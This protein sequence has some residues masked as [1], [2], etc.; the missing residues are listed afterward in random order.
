MQYTILCLLLGKLRYATVEKV[1]ILSENLEKGQLLG[2]WRIV[3]RSEFSLLHPPPPLENI[4]EI[5]VF[6]RKFLSS[7]EVEKPKLPRKNMLNILFPITRLC[8]KTC[9]VYISI[10]V[11]FLCTDS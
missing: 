7:E 3:K 5:K 11:P 4:S 10:N 1:F 8:H 9:S 2:R 6:K